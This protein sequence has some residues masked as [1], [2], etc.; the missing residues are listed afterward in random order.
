M[1]KI[2]GKSPL[3]FSKIPG[4]ETMRSRQFRS[5][6][7]VPDVLKKS[8]QEAEQQTRYQEVYDQLM[9]RHLKPPAQETIDWCSRIAL[10][11]TV[12]I[13]VEG[14]R[15]V[16]I[17]RAVNL[18]QRYLN[19][20]KGWPIPAKV[21]R[22]G[23]IVIRHHGPDTLVNRVPDE[24]FTLHVSEREVHVNARTVRGGIASIVNMIRQMELGR[25]PALYRGTCN[26]KPQFARR[27][28][29][30]VLDGKFFSAS[31]GLDP[32]LLDMAV[33]TGANSI[34]TNLDLALLDDGS[35]LPE[36]GSR[37]NVQRREFLVKT[38]SLAADY[39]LDIVGHC[40]NPR[41]PENHKL[42]KKHPEMRGALHAMYKF[43]SLCSGHRGAVQALGKCWARLVED[44][45]SLAAMTWIIG[46]E[47]FYH[48][49][50]RAHP[51]PEG[52]R[53]NCARCSRKNADQTIAEFV[54]R[55]A[56]SVHQ[57]RDTV[58]IIAWPY[59][60]FNWMEDNEQKTFIDNLDPE[61]VAFITCPEKD[62]LFDR[63]EHD[64]FAWDY[65]ISC[66]GP[67]RRFVNQ[68]HHCRSRNIPFYVLSNTSRM[69][70]FHGATPYIPA[71]QSWHRRWQVVRRSSAK[72]VMGYCDYDSG[73]V[74]TD[75]G[76]WAAWADEKEFKRILP[77]IAWARYGR[78][79]VEVHK[80][81]QYF[82]RAMDVYPILAP[83]YFAG[84]T[85]IGPAQP[86]SSNLAVLNDPVYRYLKAS[87]G[88]AITKGS[89]DRQQGSLALESLEPLTCMIQPHD[90]DLSR[91]GILLRS[92][93]KAEKLW[94]QGIICLERAVSEV[95]GSR[96][97]TDLH[98]E[99]YV[100]RWIW[101]SLVT[102]VNFVN[103]LILRDPNARYFAPCSKEEQTARWRSVQRK[104]KKIFEAER[105]NTV[106]ALA[107][108][109]RVPELNL[110]YWEYGSKAA[111]ISEMLARKIELLDS[112][113]KELVSP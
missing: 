86:V 100:A 110:S 55:L 6:G 57:A 72:G 111:T 103:V 4:R 53:T 44:I 17:D 108:I 18:L 73:A 31:E 46:G 112:D 8:R 102:S 74:T 113:I 70:E 109:R 26:L 10:P 66:I 79:G 92:L 15:A 30:T 58:E 9:Q 94:S 32:R 93:Q 37:T 19:K 43:Y 88:Q 20:Y 82:S 96:E 52:Q 22:A 95:K 56:C 49:Y 11:H 64:T 7:H 89:P 1:E 67:G 81:W 105:K 62:S 23:K 38:A 34:F 83:G 48:C 12:P 39:G 71:L 16:G 75:L 28:C 69:W 97:K 25:A 61:H 106:S 47:S 42:W 14:P 60:G 107:L 80:A 99:E 90:L 35:V 33:L 101:M 5:Q 40:F 29:F 59:S 21:P 98:R 24:R 68:K 85:V 27:T 41:L 2:K 51:K 54:N 63:G 3:T 65:S 45:P 76:Y 87:G 50:M 78:V 13:L 36:M 77:S 84:P 104:M 91:E